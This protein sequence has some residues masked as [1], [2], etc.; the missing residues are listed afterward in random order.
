MRRVIVRCTP[1]CSYRVRAGGVVM[2]RLLKNFKTGNLLRCRRQSIPI[3]GGQTFS[4]MN[5]LRVCDICRICRNI[6]IEICM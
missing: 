6:D 4:W 2:V 3:H 5:L 1:E